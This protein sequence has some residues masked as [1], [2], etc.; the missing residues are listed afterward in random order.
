MSGRFLYSIASIMGRDITRLYKALPGTTV[1]IILFCLFGLFSGVALFFDT[2]LT[3]VINW[4]AVGM[5]ALFLLLSGVLFLY[6]KEER[7]AVACVVAAG[8]VCGLVAW[9]GLSAI[10][11]FCDKKEMSFL[12]QGM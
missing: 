6:C 4:M 10:E 1:T 11:T 5:F 3:T 7:R 8:V 12:C 9:G 2:N